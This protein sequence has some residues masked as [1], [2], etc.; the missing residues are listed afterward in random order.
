MQTSVDM[1][2][3]S[4][5]IAYNRGSTLHQMHMIEY[6]VDKYWTI[7]NSVSKVNIDGF[8]S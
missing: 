3:L 1:S 5:C 6:T 7:N 8:F 4:L 2:D